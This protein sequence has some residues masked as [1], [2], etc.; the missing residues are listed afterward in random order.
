MTLT[1]STC[2]ACAI[3]A[4]TAAYAAALTAI[5]DTAAG[6]TAGLIDRAEAMALTSVE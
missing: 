1:K 5:A 4:I 2:L 3:M 6:F